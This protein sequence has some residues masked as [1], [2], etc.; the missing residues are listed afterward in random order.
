VDATG[1]AYVVWGVDVDAEIVERNQLR[2]VERED[3]FDEDKAG[4]REGVEDAE[5]AR[6]GGEIVDRA[7][8]GL[9]GG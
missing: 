3:A 6:V 1:E 8:D 9:A 4:W 5:D 2:I 7:L